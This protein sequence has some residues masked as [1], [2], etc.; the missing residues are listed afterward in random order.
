MKSKLTIEKWLRHRYN[1]Q[2]TKKLKP[3]RPLTKMAV[4]FF[5]LL[6]GLNEKEALIKLLELRTEVQKLKGDNVLLENPHPVIKEAILCQPLSWREYILS[7]PS[8]ISHDNIS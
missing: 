4:E 7:N 8:E 1:S 5:S 3:I 2:S 6:N